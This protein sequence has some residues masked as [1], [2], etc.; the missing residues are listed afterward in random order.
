MENV[1]SEMYSLL[2]DTYIK[3][4]S[5]KARLFDGIESIPAIGKKAKWAMKWINNSR[6]FG[7]RLV[8]FA[9]VEGI[10]FS[11][12]F[13]AIYWLKKQGVMPGLC[14][15]NLLI[16]RDE[17]LH[18]SFACLLYTIL[19]S[20]PSRAIV[21][22]IVTD[23]VAIEKEFVTSALPVS[24]I[25]MNAEL[26]CQYIEF[27]A[28]KLIVDLGMEKHYN[29]T[30]PFEWLDLISL[31]GV[32]NFFERRVPEYKKSGI[33]TTQSRELCLDADF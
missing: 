25:G 10:F 12:S 2:I 22:D 29:A 1:H 19:R 5:E 8:A 9:V 27:C 31:E 15:S 21:I 32:T 23:A 3:D 7:E 16:S 11:G 6:S 4:P 17:A 20:P 28:D 14:L 30:N 24:L 18:T 26:M 33:I 13:C